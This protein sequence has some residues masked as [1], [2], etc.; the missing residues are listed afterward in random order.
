MVLI[1]GC[2]KPMKI[3]SQAAQP[4][5]KAVNTE[6]AEPEAKPALGNTS[7]SDGFNRTNQAAEFPRERV[8]VGNAIAIRQQGR[9][10]LRERFEGLIAQ[11]RQIPGIQK[12][13]ID[14][15]AAVDFTQVPDIKT[16]IGPEFDE[17]SLVQHY[18]LEH[19]HAE[20]RPENMM[21]LQANTL[22]PRHTD[23]VLAIGVLTDK[24]SGAPLGMFVETFSKNGE[25]KTRSYLEHLMMDTKAPHAKGLGPR[26]WCQ[27][28]FESISFITLPCPLTQVLRPI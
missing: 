3:Q 28:P 16:H 20:L 9:P 13:D 7:N 6:R 25:G 19:K 4:K 26:K 14:N 1:G 24:S 27:G 11:I 22:K 23:G 10:S 5:K 15:L 2:L 17:A 18:K 12:E 8:S 21:L